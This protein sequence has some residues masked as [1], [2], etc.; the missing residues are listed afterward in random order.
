MIERLRKKISLKEIIF[1]C[2]GIAFVLGINVYVRLFP[3]FLP[4]FRQQADDGVRQQ[5]AMRIEKSGRQYLQKLD[6]SKRQRFVQRLTDAY[7]KKNHREIDAQVQRQYRRL[8]GPYQSPENNTYILEIDGWQ[9][10]RYVQNYIAKGRVGDRSDGRFDFDML[11]G[12]KLGMPLDWHKSLFIISALLYSLVSAVIHISLPVFLFYVPLFYVSVFLVV[13]YLFCQRYWGHV[14]A[15]VACS[16]VGLANM[17]LVR[18]TAGWFDTDVFNMLFPLV[19][20]WSYLWCRQASLSF[21]G[22]MRVIVASFWVGFFS[23]AWHFWWFIVAVI[24]LYEIVVF[25][26]ASCSMFWHKTWHILSYKRQMAVLFLYSILSA[27]WVFIFCGTAPFVALADQIQLAVSLNSFTTSSVW[28]NTF[29]TVSE[30]GAMQPWRIMSYMDARLLLVAL[31][32]VM[33]WLYA[34]HLRKVH[35]SSGQ[36]QVLLIMIIWMA[37]MLFASTRGI[38]FVMFVFIPVGIILGLIGQRLFDH[39]SSRGMKFLRGFVIGVVVITVSVFFSNAFKSAWAILPLMNDTW[40]ETLLLMAKATPRQAVINSWW[41][42]GDWFESI[43][44]RRVIFDGQSQNTPQAY[45]MARVLLASDEHEAERILRMLNNGGNQAFEI[46]QKNVKDPY[47]A[48]TLLHKVLLLSRNDAEM[49]LKNSV[50]PEELSRLMS[51]MFDAPGPAYFIVDNSMTNKMASI[52]FLGN[53]DF[54]RKYVV[55]AVHEGVPQ[56]KVVSWLVSWGIERSSAVRMFEQA[57]TLPVAKQNE[58]ISKRSRFASSL[59]V[60]VQKNTVVLFDGGLV[61]DPAIGMV[62]AYSDR[63]ASYHLPRSVFVAQ[64]DGNIRKFFMPGKTAAFSV[65]IFQDA[66]QYRAFKLD[67]QLAE[68]LF[69][70]LYYLGGR[71][72]QHFKAYHDKKSLED[73]VRVF[74]IQWDR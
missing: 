16:Y 33:G 6:A 38:R 41:D 71:G 50:S 57:A 45:W 39:F 19:I 40:Y 11:N 66:G 72:L 25:S 60:G 62:Y 65:L 73:L 67:G 12:A 56:E 64:T 32:I 8:I 3:A 5:I 43:A 53:W 24:F 54:M 7:I 34:R 13:L 55:D 36:R 70:R 15:L 26:I 30:L 49:L 58:W 20:V 23:F 35:V 2:L 47:A 27:A 4:Q 42:Y 10:M 28:P 29:F 59:L 48:I 46:I 37:C 9:W 14:T 31:W 68:S 44:Q 63:S 61:Y 17:F 21:S 22:I 52:S 69:V 74:Q 1:F 18:S 51:I